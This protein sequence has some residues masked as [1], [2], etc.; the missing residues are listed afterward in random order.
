MRADCPGML[1]TCRNLLDKA[2]GYASTSDDV[3]EIDESEEVL[4]RPEELLRRYLRT[5]D[6]MIPEL[7][8]ATDAV[9]FPRIEAPFGYYTVPGVSG[10]GNSYVYFY[11]RGDPTP[12][13]VAGRIHYIFQK[14]GRTKFALRRNLPLVNATLDPDPFSAFWHD[15]FQ[16]K[17]VSTT[18]SEVIEVV[19]PQCIL[20]H[21]ATWELNA[22]V[23]AVLAIPK[24]S[25]RLALVG[26]GLYLHN[27]LGLVEVPTNYSFRSW[28]N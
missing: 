1:K 27:Y 9:F 21:T 15:G 5:P 18:F 22:E 2:F 6:D 20:G 3:D 12:G 24:V 4:L 8:I 16:A 19:E 11:P 7:G 23:V 13:W 26:L 28:S 10:K 17:L 25:P 14:N